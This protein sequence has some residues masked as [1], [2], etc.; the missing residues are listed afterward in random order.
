MVNPLNSNASSAQ[1]T[2]VETVQA[3]PEATLTTAIHILREVSEFGLNPNKPI[4]MADLKQRFIECSTQWHAK[5]KNEAVDGAFVI[6]QD[7]IDHQDD[8]KDS[9]RLTQ[10]KRKGL[11]LA[12]I[13]LIVGAIAL[14]ILV[15]PISIAGY[16]AGFM[17][18]PGITAIFA[19]FSLQNPY[20]AK[21]EKLRNILDTFEHF[22]SQ[23]DFVCIEYNLDPK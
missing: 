13:A 20:Y 19:G 18:F 14:T 21:A 23:K 5:L 11:A 7:L 12:G 1:T 6:A 4:E 15:F 3:S 2:G 16:L 17:I 22:K 9:S 10:I 8:I